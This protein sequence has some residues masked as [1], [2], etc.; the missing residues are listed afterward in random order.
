M[1][2][3]TVKAHTPGTWITKQCHRTVMFHKE[4]D[5]RWRGEV[6]KR[7]GWRFRPPSWR[8]LFGYLILLVLLAYMV[9]RL[10]ESV[11][12]IIF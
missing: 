1:F 12:R 9:S 10:W 5:K 4:P 2:S 3:K 7:G 6:V 11:E 8:H